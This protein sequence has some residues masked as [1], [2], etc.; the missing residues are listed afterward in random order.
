MTQAAQRTLFWEVLQLQYPCQ[1]NDSLLVH[2]LILVAVV[3]FSRGHV[4]ASDHK[5]MDEVCSAVSM[6]LDHL[7]L[8]ICVDLN[9]C[10]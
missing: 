8:C 3:S 4:Q 9:L 5:Q 10:S 6:Q 2:L 7:A 1:F